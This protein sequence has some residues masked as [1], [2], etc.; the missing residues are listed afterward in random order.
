MSKIFQKSKLG[1]DIKCLKLMDI[2]KVGTIF[3]INPTLPVRAKPPRGAIAQGRKSPHL[4][5]ARKVYALS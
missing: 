1:N 3:E 2:I 4:A 5:G